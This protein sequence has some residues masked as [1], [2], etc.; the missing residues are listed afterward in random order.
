[1]PV[2]TLELC[3]LVSAMGGAVCMHV[4]C[5]CVCLCLCACV[6]FVVCVCVECVI[7]CARVSV[8]VWYVL[9]RVHACVRE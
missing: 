1:M 2:V 5:V 6:V 9:L 4:L 7:A 3:V 8:Y